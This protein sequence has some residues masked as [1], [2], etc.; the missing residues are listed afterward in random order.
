VVCV[1]LVACA[2]GLTIWLVSR[3][4]PSVNQA[5]ARAALPAINRYLVDDKQLADFG[6]TLDADLHPKVLC[7]AAILQITTDG[8]RW[9]VALQINCGEFARR[10][11]TLLEQ[12]LGYP[13]IADTAT[14]TKAGG[15]YQATNL[16][17]W[18]PYW[19]KAWVDNNFSSQA[20][21]WILSAN[22]PTAP[23]PISQAWKVF[24]FPAGTPAANS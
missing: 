8:R 21:R 2:A 6:G 12:E 19:D 17:V 13:G 16:Q 3:Q 24:N 9:H 11:T 14:L 5:Q 18:P 22:P 15:R 4:H 20:A 10:N 1:A 7:D 23:N